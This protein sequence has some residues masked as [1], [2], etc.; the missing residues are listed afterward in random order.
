MIFCLYVYMC[1]YIYIYAVGVVGACFFFLG[2]E[3]GDLFLP[4]FWFETTRALE[5]PE[6][7]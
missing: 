1:M 5:V 2:G 3:G 6:T 7:L 4:P